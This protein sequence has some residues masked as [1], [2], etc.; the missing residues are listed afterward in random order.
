MTNMSDP[1]DEYM[2]DTELDYTV[3]KPKLNEAFS[4][5]VVLSNLPKVPAAKVDKLTSVLKKLAAKVGAID[6]DAPFMMPVNEK[7]GK[8]HGFAFIT[9][10]ESSDA[11]RCTEALNSYQVR[12]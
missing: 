1:L 9:Y 11:G 10:K 6:E 3:N 4:A 5:T 8:T 7:E 2:S 12:R